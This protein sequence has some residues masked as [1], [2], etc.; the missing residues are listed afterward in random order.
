[1]ANSGLEGSHEFL[2]KDLR[3]PEFDLLFA[4]NVRDDYFGVLVSGELYSTIR[5]HPMSALSFLETKVAA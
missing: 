5:M 2:V 4:D 1:V 3:E